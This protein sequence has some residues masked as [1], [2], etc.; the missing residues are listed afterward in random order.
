M[1]VCQRLSRFEQLRTGNTWDSRA[2]TQGSAP[3]LGYWKGL[4]SG[5]LNHRFLPGSSGWSAPLTGTLGRRSFRGKEK[6]EEEDRQKGG[7]QEE[8][9][10]EEEGRQKEGR[11]KEKGR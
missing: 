1:G 10:A 4:V 11:N 3:R 6:G 7:D 5:G 8:G 9:R 2:R